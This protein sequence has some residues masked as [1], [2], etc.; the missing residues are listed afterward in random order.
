MR[1]R[2]KPNTPPAWIGVALAFYAFIAI[3]IAES[4]LGVLL[5]SILTTYQLTP[6]TVTALFFSQISGY[7]VAAL[8]SSIL[9]HYIGLTRM[10]LLA[11]ISVMSALGAYA[12]ITHWWLMVITGTLLGLGIG[13]IDAGINTFVA[14]DQ[15]NANLMGLLHAFYGIGA[16]AGPAIATTL[17]TLGVSWR[18][19]YWVFAGIVALLV[20]ALFWAVAQRH[21]LMNTPTSVSHQSAGA[22]LRL[23][24]KTPTVLAAGFLLLIYVGTEASLGNW[25]YAVQTISRGTPVATAGYSIAAYWFGLTL[26]RLS[27]GQLTKRFGS[28]RLMDYSLTLLTAGLIIWWLFPNQL[29]SLPLIGFALSAIF[30]TTIW[31][32]PRRVP[33]A[34]VPAAIGFLTSVGSVGA[35]SIPT[36]LGW[37]ADNVGLEVIPML[38]VPLAIVMMVAHRWLVNHTSI[39]VEAS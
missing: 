9:S 25:A 11:A 16:L 30:P 36:G 4:G 21:P 10:I 17:L 8:T 33:A 12:F 13:L 24:F 20:V 32:M 14:H 5:P 19:A 23:A 35:V 26:G 28:I 3:G 22:N 39:S 18:S 27:M 2:P 15:R 29:W 1:I 38:M 6:A 34:I 31:L 37:I 7:V